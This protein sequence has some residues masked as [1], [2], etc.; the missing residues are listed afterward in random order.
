MPPGSLFVYT[1]S[2]SVCLLPIAAI[3]DS[4]FFSTINCV[5]Y[6]RNGVTSTIDINYYNGALYVVVQYPVTP[7][8]L[9]VIAR[10]YL[11]Q[12]YATNPVV[13]GAD[14]SGIAVNWISSNLYLTYNHRGTIMVARTDGRFEKTLISNLNQPKG[15]AIEITHRFVA[16]TSQNTLFRALN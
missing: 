3:V 9:P 14:A 2:D 16:L 1:L 13:Y 4:L 12:Q 15:I 10:L 6:R 11:R 5:K 8:P 7:V